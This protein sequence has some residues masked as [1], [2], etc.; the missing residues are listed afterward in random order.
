MNETLVFKS[1]IFVFFIILS[2][3]FS[4]AETAFTAINRIKLQSILKDKANKAHHLTYLLKNPKKLLTCILIG[5]NLANIAATSFATAFFI[6]LL[7]S[8]G[9]TSFA[10]TLSLITVFITIIL[11]SFAG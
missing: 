3:F 10:T 9:I 1:F 2:A 4:G 8:I 6:D 7:S 5:N 11:L